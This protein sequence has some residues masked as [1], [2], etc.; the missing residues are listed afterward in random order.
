[1]SQSAVRC[2]KHQWI[3]RQSERATSHHRLRGERR[4]VMKRNRASGRRG[5]SPSRTAQLVHRSFTHTEHTGLITDAINHRVWSSRNK[6]TVPIVERVRWRVMRP[7]V[8]IN[9][10][11]AWQMSKQSKPSMNQLASKSHSSACVEGSIDAI[12]SYERN[13]R[14]D[15][16][17]T[18]EW[19]E[20]ERNVRCELDPKAIHCDVG[21][22]SSDPRANDAGHTE[23]NTDASAL[24]A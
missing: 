15:G 13:G 10:L 14:N 12:M 11:M 7:T 22:L 6:F 24:F 4:T 9:R 17:K 8:C 21:R 1:M 16:T 23:G 2:E 3:G 20:W 19:E 5:H 18:Q